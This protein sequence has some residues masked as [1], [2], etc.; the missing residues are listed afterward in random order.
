MSHELRQIVEGFLRA[1]A[2]RPDGSKISKKSGEV[3]FNE[4]D[5]GH[6][7]FLVESGR[8][9]ITHNGAT[10]ETVEAGG[11]VGEMALVDAAT[12]RRS[13][14][15]HA[16]SDSVLVP[17]N[18]RRFRELVQ[19]NPDFALEMMKVLVRRIREMNERMG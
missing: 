10:L 1:E 16:I 2:G 13:A 7:M 9:D 6:F 19:R 17:I 12:S 11:V 14:A 15:A 3:V 4:G 8:I 5:K 18:Q